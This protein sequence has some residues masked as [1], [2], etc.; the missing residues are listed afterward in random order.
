MNIYIY[1]PMHV[2]VVPLVSEYSGIAVVVD[3][4]SSII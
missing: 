4:V 2:I 3:A 1:I